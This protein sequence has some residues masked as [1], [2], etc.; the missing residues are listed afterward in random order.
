MLHN[1]PKYIQFFPSFKCN[2]GCDFCFNRGISSTARETS[3]DELAFI[4]QAIKEAGIYELDILGG[5]PTL[6]SHLEILIDS[7]SKQNMRVF[8][9]SNGTDINFLKHLLNKNR[10]WDFLNIG[11]SLND[12]IS[13]ELHDF[14]LRYKPLLKS[15]VIKKRGLPEFARNFLRMPHIR[16]YLLFMDVLTKADLENSL[17][18]PNYLKILED[19]NRT[20]KNIL[21]VYCEGF[22]SSS[23]RQITQFRC[24]AG[25]T[26]LSVMPDGSVYPCYLFFR[27]EHYKLGNIL[28]DDMNRILNSPVLSFFRT[29]KGN[30]CPLTDCLLHAKCRG[31]CPAISLLINGNIE[32]P[33]PRCM[34][35][36]SFKV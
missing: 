4:L 1:Y 30:N 28:Y 31:G 25:S 23:S 10:A 9:S 35:L 6:Y 17:S 22:M 24:P 32:S 26:K 21:P 11:L 7:A 12:E 14:I 33:D 3:P 2:R 34:V 13:T 20:F 18:L 8:L 36:D 27:H 15:V 29:F 19:L 16:Y 5:E